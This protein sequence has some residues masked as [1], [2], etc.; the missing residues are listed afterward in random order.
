MEPPPATARWRWHPGRW[1]TCCRRSREADSAEP[2]SAAVADRRTYLREDHGMS[3]FD[4]VRTKAEELL[5]RAEQVYGE[6][7]ATPRPPSRARRTYWRP[8]RRRKPPSAPDTAGTTTGSPAPADPTLLLPEGRDADTG[9]CGSGNCRRCS[10]VDEL[11]V[12]GRGC[13]AVPA[14]V[15]GVGRLGGDTGRG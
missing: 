13:P 9:R 11:D 14:R 4:K 6:S 5:G 12:R 15:P 2:T 1:W 7:T 8:R 3:I 10:T